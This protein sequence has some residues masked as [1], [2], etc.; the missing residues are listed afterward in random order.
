VSSFEPGSAI[1]GHG[2]PTVHIPEL[3]LNNFTTRLG[4]RSGR[5]L[6]SLFPHVYSSWLYPPVVLRLHILDMFVRDI[7]P[8]I[9]GKTGGDISQS[10]RLYI[11]ETSPLCLPTRERQNTSSS[12][13]ARAAIYTENEVAS[14]G[15]FQHKVWRVWVAIQA[16]ND[17]HR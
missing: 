13:G 4:R 6:G 2:R 11:C 5:F 9:R 12:A 8:R 14:G 7:G 16:Q 15:Y 1:P 3:I 10:T 17:G